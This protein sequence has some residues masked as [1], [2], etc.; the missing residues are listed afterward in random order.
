MSY[1]LVL[2]KRFASS[3]YLGAFLDIAISK[4]SCLFPLLFGLFGLPIFG[5]RELSIEVHVVLLLMLES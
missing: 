4:A 1:L 3:S 5:N 2:L